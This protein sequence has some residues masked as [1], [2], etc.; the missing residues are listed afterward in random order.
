MTHSLTFNKKNKNKKQPDKY[1]HKLH[2]TREAHFKEAYVHKLTIVAYWWRA[3]LQRNNQCV[4]EALRPIN[5]NSQQP[6]R[7]TQWAS[8]TRCRRSGG[9]LTSTKARPCDCRAWARTRRRA[10][11][12][13]AVRV[14]CSRGRFCFWRVIVELNAVPKMKAWKT[15]TKLQRHLCCRQK[16]WQ[17]FVL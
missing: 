14:C 3:S 13:T 7:W 11:A 12:C 15:G 6:F 10:T 5:S 1:S 16:L 17:K 9:N 4:L 2:F 8:N